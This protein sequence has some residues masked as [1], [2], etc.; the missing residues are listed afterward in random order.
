LMIKNKIM[1]QKIL[2]VKN[3]I[4]QKFKIQKKYVVIN[5][6]K[7]KGIQKFKKIRCHK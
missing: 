2:E 6:S 4:I 7:R 3:K 1:C 5:N